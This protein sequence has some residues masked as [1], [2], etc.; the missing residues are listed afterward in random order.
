M[1]GA[2]SKASSRPGTAKN[3]RAGTI[4]PGTTSTALAA[5]AQAANDG[6]CLQISNKKDER[7]KKVLA[8]AMQRIHHLACDTSLGSF[9][10]H[11]HH[12][13]HPTQLAS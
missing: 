4:R 3:V 11:V 2:M 12:D 8:Q 13:D 10:I 1:S 6:V 5:T 9:W 7:A